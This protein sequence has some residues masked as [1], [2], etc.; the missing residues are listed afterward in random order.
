MSCPLVAGVAALLLSARPDVTPTQIRD[1]LRL[2]ASQASTPDNLLGWGIVNAE[3]AL[4]WLNTTD[5][6]ADLV[7]SRNRLE[8]NVPNPFNPST[9]IRY[10][11]VSQS[12]VTLRIYDAAGRR[13]RTLVDATQPPRRYDLQWNGT[14]D[15][16]HRLAAGVYLCRLEA[17]PVDRSDAAGFTAVRK[18]VYLP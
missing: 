14:D 6:T 3:A 1:A 5:V 15:R 4:D 12:H 11:L 7:V 16:G 10:D 2:T 9:R 8:P 13:V 18:M 17:W